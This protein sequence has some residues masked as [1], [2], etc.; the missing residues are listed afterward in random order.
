LLGQMPQRASSLAQVKSRWV[1]PAERS[2]AYSTMSVLTFKRDT[3]RRHSPQSLVY[4]ASLYPASLRPDQEPPI[5]ANRLPHSLGNGNSH[6][7]L[8]RTLFDDDERAPLRLE[9][10]EAV[11]ETSSGLFGV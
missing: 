1:F 11:K 10:E 4:L 7:V 3:A 2:S 8:L 6:S 5:L 9:R